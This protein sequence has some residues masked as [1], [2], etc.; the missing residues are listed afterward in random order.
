MQYI[1]FAF[2]WID[3]FAKKLILLISKLVKESVCMDMDKDT[4]IYPIS[5]VCKFLGTSRETI[6]AYENYGLFK[7][8]KTEKGRRL[9]SQEDIEWLK[10]IQFLIHNEKYSIKCVRKMLEIFNCYEVVESDKEDKEKVFEIKQKKY[11][12]LMKKNCRKIFIVQ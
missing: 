12:E 8:Y 10:H 4:P 9:Y 3:S 1:Y 2:Y 11:W 7:V 5:V 6:R